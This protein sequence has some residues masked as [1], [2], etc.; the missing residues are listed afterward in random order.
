MNETGKAVFL[1][2]ASQDA[3]AAK[4]ICESLRAAGVEVWLDQEGGLAGGDAWDAKIRGQIASCALFIP[5]VSAN[6]Q[7]RLEG[8]FRVEWK[9]AVRRTH[10]M[11]TAKAFLL[12]VVIDDT[13]DAEAHVP[14]EFREVQWTLLRQGYG[15]QARLGDATQVGPGLDGAS[16]AAFCARVKTLLGSSEVARVSRPVGAEI[17]G[18][19]THATADDRSVAVLP[20]ANMSSD[21]ENEYFC[22][23]I[24]EEITS[25]LSKVGQLQVAGRTSAF[26]F[27]GRTGDLRGIGRALNVGAVLEGSV[28]K[29]GHRLR[30]TAQLIKVADGYHLWSERYDREVKDIVDIQDE[31]ALA[32]VEA[33]KVTLLGREKTLVL[34]RSTEN[35]EAYQLCLKAY[36]AWHRWTDEGF[37]TAVTLFN[38]AFER[39][40]DYALAHFGLGDCYASRAILGREPFEKAKTRPLFETAI[41]LDPNLADAHAVLGAIIDGVLEWNWPLAESRCQTALALDPRSAHI[42]NVHGVLQSVMGRHDEAV[43]TYRRAI[44]LDPLGPLWN[45]CFI[46][47]LL[48]KRDWAGALRQTQVTL[49]VAPEYWFALQLAGQ[50]HLALSQWDEAVGKFE[51]AVRSS[52]E[53]PY[54]I[55][56]LGH[57]LA[58]AGRRDEALEQLAELRRRAETHYV[59]A[60][61]RAY[62]HAGLGEL[63]EALA[64]LE[65]SLGAGDYWTIYSLTNFAVL[66]DLRSD[67]RFQALVR[68]IGL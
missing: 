52:G 10:A 14:D 1:S 46:Q 30:I 28:R 51:R 33:L 20:F 63:G 2:Y 59:P 18:Q 55:G 3:E 19:E 7:S 54:V 24:A 40:P 65:R 62:V 25:A 12:P 53:V 64:L 45:A 67:P 15:G 5:I 57:A 56:L 66:D 22:D 4:R 21:A 60:T 61:A 8:Y 39:D 41:R 50:A 47:A 11:A 27:K 17:M 44:E 35:P 29:A 9:L 43:A 42:R 16:V 13:R 68:R 37:R 38:Q 32:V 58:K 6:T 23:G 26:S 36:H 49:D 31:I 34:K 48:G